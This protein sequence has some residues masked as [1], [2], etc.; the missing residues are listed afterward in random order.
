MDEIMEDAAVGLDP[1][2]SNFQRH[3]Q[4]FSQVSLR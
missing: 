4:Q 1:E 2:R 3:M